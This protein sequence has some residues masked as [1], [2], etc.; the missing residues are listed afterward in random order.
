MNGI[1][2]TTTKRNM[3]AEPANDEYTTTKVAI[4]EDNPTLRQ[5][6]SDLIA[7]TPG[8]KCVCTCE[9]AEEALEKIPA[10]R[11]HVVLMDIHLPGESGI[12]CTA[13]LREKMPKIQVIM[14][15]VYK[16][17][18]MIFQAIKE[19]GPSIDKSVLMPPWGDTFSDDE[20]RDLVVYLRGLCKCAFG[21]ASP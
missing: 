2:M 20:I 21:A 4:V 14:L 18:Q 15:T 7:S 12:A 17:I 13:R 11:P 16:D 5:Y 1:L 6:L 3:A 9:S 19:G 8:Y 10:Q